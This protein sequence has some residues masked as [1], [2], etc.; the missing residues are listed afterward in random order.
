MDFQNDAKLNIERMLKE[1]RSF[2]VPGKPGVTRLPFSSEAKEACGYLKKEMENAGMSVYTDL[3]GNVRGFLRGS[4][5]NGPIIMLGSHYDTVKEG[6]EYDGIAG[7]VCAIEVARAIGKYVPERKYA[8][9]VVAFNDE[10]GMMFG[11]GCLGSKAI[12]GMVDSDYITGLTDENGISIKEWMTRWG[13][14]PEKLDSA[15]EDLGNIRGFF[16]IHIE[17]GPVLDT[18]K[19]ELGIVN[20]IVGL[21]RCMVTIEGR[22][23]H[24]GTTPM[25]MRQD[26]ILA[27]SKVISE[28]D[29]FA[30]E[31]GGGAVATCGFIRAYPNAMN[32]VASKCEFTMD[33]RS[34]KDSSIDNIFEKAVNILEQCKKETGIEYN[35]DIK[36]RQRPVY[37]NNVFI[38]MLKEK[39]GECGYSYKEML[40]GAAHDAMIF[41]DKVPAVMVFVPSKDGRSHCPEESSSVDDLAKAAR[42]V[43]ETISDLLN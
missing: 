39:C 11:S 4:A 29:G 12:A 35:I 10:E 30:A 6:G 19:T 9:E 38:D 21:L 16:E 32:V 40:S 7:V 24:A 22:A 33:I 2:T 26:A 28:L 15:K 31:E 13:S 8:L 37:M 43:F 34:A 1:L 18:E 3:V 36:L 25:D 17:Q 23:D 42:I 41:A 27:A 5:E 20:C 14:D